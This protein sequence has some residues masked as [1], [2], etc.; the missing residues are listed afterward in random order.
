MTQEINEH[1]FIIDKPKNITVGLVSQKYCK[2]LHVGLIRLINSYTQPNL[3]VSTHRQKEALIGLDLVEPV[4]TVIDLETGPAHS[5]PVV[6]VYEIIVEI[7]SSYRPEPFPDILRQL[8]VLLFDPR[9]SSLHQF[10]Q[11]LLE[12][13]QLLLRQWTHS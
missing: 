3:R 7:L 1:I 5:C 9:V 11:P 12:P 8:W 4:R 2:A 10:D 13:L 6:S